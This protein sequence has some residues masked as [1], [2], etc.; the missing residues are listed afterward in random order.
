MQPIHARIPTTNQ[1]GRGLPFLPKLDIAVLNIHSYYYKM[2]RGANNSQESKNHEAREVFE[3]SWLHDQVSN[4]NKH[5]LKNS[6]LFSTGSINH[7]SWTIFC[8]ENNEN[9]EI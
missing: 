2:D 6:S 3:N 8:C 9:R 4:Q 5:G 1:L 7:T